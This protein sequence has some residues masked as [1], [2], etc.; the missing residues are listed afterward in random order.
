MLNNAINSFVNFLRC[1]AMQTFGLIYCVVAMAIAVYRKDF[2]TI[3]FWYFL[4]LFT[5]ALL[6]RI[7]F[8][9]NNQLMPVLIKNP[10]ISEAVI[11]SQRHQV[12]TNNT[13]HKYLG[14]VFYVGNTVYSIGD[15]FIYGAM[16]LLIGEIL[17]SFIIL[18]TDVMV[19]IAIHFS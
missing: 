7:V 6:N 4:I 8:Y 16:L 14:D 12:M 18:S 11:E 17:S 15:F 1:P 10:E 5:G 19:K 9:A 2:S 13:K 3:S